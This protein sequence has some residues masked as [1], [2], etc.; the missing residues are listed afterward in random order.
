L[1]FAHVVRKKEGR[2]EVVAFFRNS[3]VYSF[4]QDYMPYTTLAGKRLRK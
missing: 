3:H 1:F 2:E 4:G